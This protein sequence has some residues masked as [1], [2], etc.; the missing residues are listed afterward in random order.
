[1]IEAV[2]E[3]HQALAASV[4]AHMREGSRVESVALKHRDIDVA[5]RLNELGGVA[6][7][8]ADDRSPGEPDRTALLLEQGRVDALR[9][10][11][12]DVEDSDRL[13]HRWRWAKKELSFYLQQEIVSL[14]AN[15]RSLEEF[16]ERAKA[17]STIARATRYASMPNEYL[18]GI[19]CLNVTR[20]PQ[21]S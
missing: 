11:G 7:L 14:G 17:I 12:T 3:G 13:C 19:S 2:A 1:M 20:A 4:Q 8:V 6:T 15:P 10:R 16:G 9:V 18:E 21:L 5:E